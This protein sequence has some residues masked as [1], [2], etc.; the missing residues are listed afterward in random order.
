[1]TNLKFIYIVVGKVNYFSEKLIKFFHYHR[2]QLETDLKIE[3]EWRGSLQRNLEQEKEK[4]TEL[5]AE[6][7]QF[8]QMKK[9]SCWLNA[10]FVAI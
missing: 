8:K 5:Q 7:Q 1:M 2:S 10:V 9:V 6:L 3:R 4:V